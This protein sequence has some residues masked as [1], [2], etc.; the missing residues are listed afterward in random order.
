M[1]LVCLTSGRSGARAPTFMTRACVPRFTPQ[2]QWLGLTGWFGKSWGQT[3]V[4][5]AGVGQE[6][7]TGA[8]VPDLPEVWRTRSHPT[9]AH[10][11]FTTILAHKAGADLGSNGFEGD[12]GAQGQ[13]RF[14]RTSPNPI[15]AHKP[16]PDSGAQAPT[17]FWRTSFRISCWHK[18]HRRFW[19][20]WCDSAPQT[21]TLVFAFN[22]F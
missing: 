10:K 2:M 7:V 14:W 22:V 1:R 16:Q 13:P 21:D 18:C 5:L 17:R 9:L 15:L 8:R 20:T 6:S 3:R 11:V 19:R 12:S 4:D